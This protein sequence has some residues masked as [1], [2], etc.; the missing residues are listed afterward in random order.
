MA[1]DLIPLCLRIME[2]EPE[3]HQTVATF[4]VQ[5][6][7]LDDDG[8]SYVCAT[9]L[10]FYAVSRVLETMV[11]NLDEEQHLTKRLLKHILRC[12]LRLADNQT[13]VYNLLFL[14]SEDAYKLLIQGKDC[15]K[16]GLTRA[17]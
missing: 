8:L 15:T 12:Y 17:I 4:I 2:T 3:L 6:I 11:Q 10:R 13:Y 14:L 7:L 1:T 16:G 9:S 5:K